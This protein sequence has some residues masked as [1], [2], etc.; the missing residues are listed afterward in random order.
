MDDVSVQIEQLQKWRSRRKVDMRI[1]TTMNSICKSLKN[2][3]KQLV[4]IQEAWSEFVPNRLN[5]VA[6]PTALRNGVLEITVD[7]SP[8][9]F[10]VNRLIRSGLLRQLQQRSGQTLKQIRVRVEH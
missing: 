9:A 8:T 1:D 5:T 2:I 4:Q 3:N 7:G 10:Q 6:V